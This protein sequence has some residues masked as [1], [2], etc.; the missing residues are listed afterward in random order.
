MMRNLQDPIPIRLH[1]MLTEMEIT[2]FPAQDLP[3]SRLMTIMG[4]R[5]RAG[6]M[7]STGFREQRTPD[8]VQGLSPS[9]VRLQYDPEIITDMSPMS[10]PHRGRHSQ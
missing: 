9:P 1:R 6:E 4:S 8:I 7:R 2:R 3:G 10:R 5:F